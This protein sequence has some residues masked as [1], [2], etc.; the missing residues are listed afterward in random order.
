MN[1]PD[2]V[3]PVSTRFY[4]MA[5]ICELLTRSPD[6]G[7]SKSETDRLGWTLP[8][9]QLVHHNAADTSSSHRPQP[10]NRARIS[11]GLSEL[12]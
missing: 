6:S 9:Q 12:R 1:F 2:G 5:V 4:L 11:F 7:S 8:V 3:D 10:V